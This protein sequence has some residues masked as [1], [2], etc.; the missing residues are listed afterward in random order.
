MIT[1]TRAQIASVLATGVD[2]LVTIFLVKILGGPHLL[3]SAAVTLCGATGTVCG[4]VTHFL[5][6]RT[7]VFRAQEQKW[8]RQLPKYMLV[9]IGNLLLNVSVLYLLTHY[10][11][12]N[13]LLAK[14]IIAIGIAV[15]YNYLLQKRFVFK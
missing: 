7:W 15:F 4:G 8:S 11:G 12:I 3:S 9:W 2:F 13:Y 10:T 6:S 14:I 5:I 1:F